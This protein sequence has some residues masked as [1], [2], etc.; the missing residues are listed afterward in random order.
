M[1]NNAHRRPH[2][3]KPKAHP[4]FCA[5]YDADPDRARKVRKSIYAECIEHELTLCGA[6]CYE[7]F[8]NL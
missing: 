8:I 7:P 6:H 4:D 1:A 2:S 3:S 5:R